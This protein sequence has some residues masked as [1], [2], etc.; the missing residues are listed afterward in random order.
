MEHLDI[1]MFPQL[2]IKLLILL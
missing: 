1:S 2:K